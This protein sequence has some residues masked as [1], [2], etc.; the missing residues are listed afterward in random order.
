M[1]TSPPLLRC[2][3][4][5]TPSPRCCSASGVAAS[6]NNT[7]ATPTASPLLRSSV[8]AAH[9]FEQIDRAIQLFEMIGRQLGVLA[10]VP[11]LPERRAAAHKGL[12]FPS[13]PDLGLVANAG[14]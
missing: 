1:P 3:C 14:A 4:V 10:P 13:S 2:C 5:Y 9:S 6:A 12:A 11:A 7:P 8:S